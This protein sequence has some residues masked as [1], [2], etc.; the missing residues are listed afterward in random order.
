MYNFD[1]TLLITDILLWPLRKVRQ[2]AWIVALNQTI[3]DQYGKLLTDFDK[4]R[5][6]SQITGQVGSLEYMLNNRYYCNGLLTDIYIENGIGGND[7]YIY[8]KA[9][10]LSKT[11]IYNRIEADDKTFI[12]SKNEF[13][14]DPDFIVF[15]PASLPGTIPGDFSIEMR[16]VVNKYKVAGTTYT[17]KTY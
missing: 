13:S 2:L 15:I 5:F 17:I 3:S 9:E 8:N 7:T 10:N 11:Y 6:E 12:F 14:G 1:L 16:A 4:Y